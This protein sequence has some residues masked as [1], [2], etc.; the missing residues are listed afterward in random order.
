MI[1]IGNIRDCSP[2]THDE[3]WAIVR[4]LKSQ[5]TK[6]KQ[7]TALSPSRELFMLYRNLHKNE[8]WDIQAFNSIY[9]PQFISDLKNGTE[10]GF[11]LLNTLY[12]AD[13]DG[14]K[15]SLA[16]FC[17]DETMCHRSIIAGLLQAVGCDVRLKTNADY[18]AYF[19]MYQKI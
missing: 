16:C 4:S 7:V 2:E 10:Q 5:S 15:I 11:T 8:K 3:T 9:V 17:T 18:R 1:T 6:I 12:Q 14:K 13:K 19:D